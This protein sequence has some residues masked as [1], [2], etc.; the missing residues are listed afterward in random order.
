MNCYHCH[1]ETN[2]KLIGLDGRSLCSHCFRHEIIAL[3]RD[4]E[5][6]E[7]KVLRRRIEDILRKSPEL[8]LIVASILIERSILKYEDLI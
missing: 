5:Q 8:L 4:C 7:L 1:T 3:L 6:D 2:N